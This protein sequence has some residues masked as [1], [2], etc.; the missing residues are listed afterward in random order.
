MQSAITPGKN[1]MKAKNL[2]QGHLRHS[3]TLQLKL[4]LHYVW[5]VLINYSHNDPDMTTDIPLTLSVD[6]KIDHSLLTSLKF[7]ML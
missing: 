3:L 4:H 5:L 7:L 6:K 1:L 2:I